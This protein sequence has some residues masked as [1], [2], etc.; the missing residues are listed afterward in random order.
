MN[1]PSCLVVIQAYDSFHQ[2]QMLS[3]HSLVE[4]ELGQLVTLLGSF[5]SLSLNQCF[6]PV[7]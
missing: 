4:L 3:C 6:L 2:H 1:T 5:S 7:A